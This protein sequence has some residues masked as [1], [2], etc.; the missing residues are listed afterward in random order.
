[1]GPCVCAGP[2]AVFPSSCPQGLAAKLHRI[3]NWPRWGQLYAGTDEG[4]S[5][6]KGEG[7][8]AGDSV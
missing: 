3:E 8:S 7:T 4:L 5:L 6:T 1:M 2:T